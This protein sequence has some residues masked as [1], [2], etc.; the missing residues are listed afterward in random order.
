LQWA[1]FFSIAALTVAVSLIRV[2]M[3]DV[4]THLA[5]GRLI[6]E[7]GMFPTTN[8]FSWTHPDATLFQQYPLFQVLLYATWSISG[9]VGLSVLTA[10]FWVLVLVT[11]MRWGGSW[12]QVAV[13]AP[14][15]FLAILGVQRHLLL[16]P[17]VLSLLLLGLMLLSFDKLRTERSWRW[18]GAIL[19]LQW[20]WANSH[21]VF[22]VGLGVQLAFVVH[23]LLSR[24]WLPIGF[25]G[26]D[27]VLGL[28][29]PVSAFLGGLLVS[30]L[31]P[32]GF[33][34]LTAPFQAIGTVATQG[35][36]TGAP[37]SA[38]LAP[39]WTDP[40]AGVVVL[41]L[42]LITV[43][44]V[45]RSRGEWRWFELALLVL[46]LALVTAALR[47]IGFFSL[48]TVGVSSRLW[49]RV[50]PPQPRRRLYVDVAL[51]LVV[52]LSVQLIASRFTSQ[53]EFLRIQPGVGRAFGE[54]PD[55][56]I[57][58][59]AANP[60]DG[61]MLNIGWGSGNVLIWEGYR[62][63]VDPRWE[64]YPRQFLL[65]SVGAIEDSSLLAAQILEWEP[66]WIVAEM[67]LSEVQ[68]RMAELV[69]SGEWQVVHA[70]TLH[71]V[72]VPGA[73][74]VTPEFVGWHSEFPRILSE[75]KIRVACWY[76]NLG[77]A[78]LADQLLDE[79]AALTGDGDPPPDLRQFG[80]C[81]GE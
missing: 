40:I 36:S 22:I 4:P 47:G 12:Q 70:D 35:A 76:T 78:D 10:V 64:T 57:E 29:K 30:S 49:H 72:L 61:N 3:A 1:A 45:I 15:W 6:L 65:D 75:E 50:E 17:E 34:S 32:I 20:M 21:Q 38:E 55:A 8:T 5:T 79:A 41:L 81:E 80:V 52:V 68:Q 53:P 59:L 18:V 62:V 37:Q 54:W 9:F 71:L 27:A 23:I 33:R 31:T 58:Y 39:V 67:R 46:G 7:D 44:A 42:L 11:W 25:S 43:S 28:R 51:V 77:E 14:A 74:T 19:A 69:R 2:G 56:T 73:E 63:F 66:D 16:R 48:L 24:K 60:P 26:Q 13:L